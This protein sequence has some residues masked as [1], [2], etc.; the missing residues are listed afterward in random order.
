MKLEEIIGIFIAIW[1]IVSVIL[2]IKIET[3]DSTY[4]ILMYLWPL[5]PLVLFIIIFKIWFKEILNQ[6]FKN[7]SRY[8]LMK[9]KLKKY[10]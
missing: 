4:K 1:I 7:N 6:L 8:R 9:L 5:T 10:Y 2:F 3:K